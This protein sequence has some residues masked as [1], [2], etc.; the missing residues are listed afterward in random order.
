MN[1]TGT[2]AIMDCTEFLH[3]YSDYDDSLLTRTEEARFRAHLAACAAC[4]RYD[5]VL[6]KGRMLARQVA[7]PAPAPDFIPRLEDRLIMDPAPRPVSPGPLA[8]G[9]FLT[10]ALAAVAGVWLMDASRP[11]LPTARAAAVHIHDADPSDRPLR[12]PVLAAVGPG[13]GTAARVDRWVAPS[14]SPLVTGP[15][16]YRAGRAT[17]PVTS[18]TRSTLD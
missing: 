15:P 3:R 17:I 8:A 6:R 13:E 7:A 11:L 12:L 10:L 5:R 18:A 9:G 1:H 16:A 2:E 4:A 14:Y